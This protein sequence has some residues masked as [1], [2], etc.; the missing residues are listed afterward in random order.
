MKERKK[1]QIY[2]RVD[3]IAM[4]QYIINV[5]DINSNVVKSLNE[6]ISDLLYII[7]L[8]RKTRHVSLFWQ[9]LKLPHSRHTC[10]KKALSLR[11]KPGFISVNIQTRCVHADKH[12]ELQK[13]GYLFQ[14]QG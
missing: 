12:L 7:V 13:T 2:T 5:K 3:R 6:R 1:P 10:M 14:L 11:A 8:L 9:G 4:Q